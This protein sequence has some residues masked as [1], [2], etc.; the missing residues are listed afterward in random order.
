VRVFVRVRDLVVGV[1]VRMICHSKL[2]CP[3][4]RKLKFREL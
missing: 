3:S 1:R 2:L 4:G